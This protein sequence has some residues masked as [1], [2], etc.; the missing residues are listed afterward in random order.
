M[1]S[2]RLE[3]TSN[4]LWLHG[5]SRENEERIG[6]PYGEIVGLERDT[7]AHIGPCRAITVVSRN[8]GELL[9]SSV[10]GVGILTEIF[11]ALYGMLSV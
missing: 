2:G 4:G 8:A 9:I 6:I 5:G 3:L 10:G 1:H 7:K 11:A